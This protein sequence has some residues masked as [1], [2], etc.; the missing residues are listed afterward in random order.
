VAP[1]ILR[2]DPLTELVDPP[3]DPWP[4]APLDPLLDVDRILSDLG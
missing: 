2:D 3:P 1:H 4:L